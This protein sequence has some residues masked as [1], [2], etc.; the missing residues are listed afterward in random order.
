LLVDALNEGAVVAAQA[1]HGPKRISAGPRAEDEHAFPIVGIGASAGGLSAF[2]G[3]LSRMPPDSGMAFVVLSHHQAG[4][5]SLLPELLSH[6]TKMPV[7]EA[8]EG[9]VVEPDHVYVAPPGRNLALSGGTLRLTRPTASRGPPLPIDSFL[10]SLA[11]DVGSRAVAIILSGTGSDGTLGVQ[12]VKAE[13]GLVMV[14][15]EASAQFSGMPASAVAT[16]LADFVVPPEEMPGR[17]L[18]WSRG[19]NPPNLQGGVA[20]ALATAATAPEEFAHILAV[21]RATTGHD[22]SGHKPSSLH[23]R[24]QRRQTLHQ[25]DRLRDYVRFLEGHEEEVHGL[26]QDLL[27]GVT[28]FFRDGGAFEAVEAPLVELLTAKPDHTTLR[29]WIPGCSTGEEA[30]SFAIL[31]AECIDRLSKPLGLQIFATDLDPQA[32]ETAR[33]GRYPEGIV[34]DVSRQRLARFFA[35]QDGMYEIKK[36]IRATLVFAIHDILGDPP[37]TRMDLVSCRNLLIYLGADFQRRVL[38]LLHHAL[39]PE[40]LLLLGSSESTTSME[41]LFTP[42]DRR[43]KLYRR[44]EAPPGEI[45]AADLVRSRPGSRHARPVA[46]QS[47]ASE[48]AAGVLARAYAPPSVLVTDRGEIVQVHGRTGRFLEPAEGRVSVNLLDMARDGLRPALTWLLRAVVR[49]P[50]QP[51]RREARLRENGDDTSVCLIA[52]KL[53]PPDALPGFILV[54]FEEP[55]TRVEPGPEPQRGEARR[56][57]EVPDP[58]R[59]ALVRE[60]ERTRGDL[61]ATIEALQS[62]NE[63]LASSTEEAQ[64]TNEELQSANEELETSRE[65]MQSLNEELQTVNAELRAKV[66]ELSQASDDLLNLLSSTSVATLFLDRDLCIKRFTAETDLAVRVDYDRLTED[67]AEVLRTLVPQ[68]KEI[69][70]GAGETTYLMRVGAYRTSQ[71]VIDGVVMTFVDI[72]RLKQLEAANEVARTHAEAIVE[73]VRQPLVTLDGR[74]RVRS[75]NPAFCSL[76]QTSAEAIEGREIFDLPGAGWDVLALRKLLEEVIPSDGI[77]E[78]YELACD[79][80]TTGRQRVRVDARRMPLEGDRPALILLAI[81]IEA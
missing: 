10:C 4:Q 31:L 44:R 54:S 45:G 55:A 59:E 53:A 22:F 24:I 28:G 25:L 42:V 34:A 49:A 38:A 13:S 48:S 41:D 40:G 63:E 14:Q 70:S 15:D 81:S 69:R 64:S 6:A 8:S 26:F 32:I 33:R 5:Q 56:E 39:N 19:P 21:L 1:Q 27:I 67:A 18:T 74:F 36:E 75:A 11:H 17:L 61:Q 78:D 3:F 16:G 37:F 71:N 72:T 47:S 30:Y 60:L 79:L 12:A 57:G 52:R 2:Q 50:E 9:V 77:V 7:E 62:A 35:K 65:E 29:V 23:R 58:E 66:I 20:P 43:W 51:A 80:S 46:L 76:F 73:T 68:E